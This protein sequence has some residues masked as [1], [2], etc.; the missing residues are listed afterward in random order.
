VR[1]AGSLAV[2]VA[3][4]ALAMH[5]GAR[6]GDPEELAGVLR[7]AVR[8]LLRVGPPPPPPPPPPP[9]NPAPPPPPPPP[10]TPT[11][12]P[13]LSPCGVGCAAG[14]RPSECRR[15]M[16]DGEPKLCRNDLQSGPPADADRRRQRHPHPLRGARRGTGRCS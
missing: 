15:G 1:M 10:P 13:S 8:D 16:A 4:A 5:P 12:R 3:G 6:A 9:Q 14:P 7:V 11:P 2:I